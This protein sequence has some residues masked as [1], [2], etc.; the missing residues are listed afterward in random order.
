[1]RHLI[2][3]VV[4]FGHCFLA[5]A[6]TSGAGSSPIPPIDLIA[7]AERILLVQA[8]ESEQFS[9]ADGTV[10]LRTPLRLLWDLTR[11]AGKEQ[12]PTFADAKLSIEWVWGR[13]LVD[14]TGR[15]IAS[16]I[17][18][19]LFLKNE[20]AVVYLQRIPDDSTQERLHAF[21]GEWKVT[22]KRCFNPILHILEEC[23]YP[24]GCGPTEVALPMGNSDWETLVVYAAD[25]LTLC[26]HGRWRCF[27]EIA[28]INPDGTG[29]QDAR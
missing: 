18:P 15:R 21:D 5:L 19:Y 2:L 26:R 3:T 9:G 7:Q 25:V 11:T 4:A 23:P 17:F 14:S 10:Y 6:T 20:I 16:L 12:E 8:G 28:H 13:V 22:E 24:T 1:M 29:R 27:G